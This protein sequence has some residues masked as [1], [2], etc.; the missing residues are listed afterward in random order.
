MDGMRL[1]RR[2]L[3]GAGAIAMAAAACGG[4]TS[5]GG[6]SASSTPTTEAM[7]HKLQFYNWAQ[8][9]NPKNVTD[10]SKKYHVAWH[11][12]NYTSNE[13]LLTEL[14]TTKGQHVYDIIVPDAD[15]VNIEK[16]LGLLLPLNHALIPN[17][18]NL[19]PHWTKLPYDPGNRYSVIKDVGITGFTLRTDRVKATLQSWKDFFD[20]LP[21]SQG[22]N[23][24]FIESPAEVIGV[25]LNSL[26]Y[27]MN[28]EDESQL[29]QAQQLLLRVRPYVDTINE[30]YL[31]D[32]ING[33]IDLGITY[34]GDGIRIRT[35]RAKQGDILVVAPQGLSEIWTDNWAISTYA[36]DP[37]AA[38]AWINFILEPANNAREMEY[39]Q[40]EVG[41]PAS[42]PMVGAAA[43]DP[44]VVFGPRILNDYEVLR[45]TPDGLRKRLEIWSAFKAA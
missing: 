35:G 31:T 27:S 6:S 44:L 26:G 14:T 3:L 20:F 12:S 41:T 29:N 25:A 24:N 28:T 40:Y 30:V 21:H 22:L 7:E 17:L 13:Q 8:Y 36:P 16:A 9:V 37:V 19:D 10:F 38:H 11:E 32:F 5:S 4:S 2:E 23:V 33:A 45:T 39:N 15:H 1:N 43:H 34:S 18:K 42:F